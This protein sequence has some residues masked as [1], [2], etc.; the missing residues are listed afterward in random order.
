MQT[1]LLSLVSRVGPFAPF[2]QPPQTYGIT[3][4]V[5]APDTPLLVARIVDVPVALPVASP[6]LLMVATHVREDDHETLDVMTVMLPSEYVPVAT[7]CLFAPLAMDG[8]TGVTLM[9]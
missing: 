2:T 5:V 4:S 3:V 6:E 7:N 9:D 1:A 8:L